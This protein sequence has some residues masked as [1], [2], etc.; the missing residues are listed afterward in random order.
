MPKS[1]SKRLLER[2][3]EELVKLIQQGDNEAF[4]ILFKRYEGLIYKLC[5]KFMTDYNIA[6]MYFDDL[7]DIAMFGLIKGTKD[8]VVDEE[9]SFLNY[10]WSI[11]DRHHMT[12]LS[13]L[14]DSKTTC[15]DPRIIEKTL[16]TMNSLQSSSANNLGLS[17]FDILNEYSKVFSTDE[18]NFLKHMYSGFEPLE[19]AEFFSWSKAKIYRLRRK[20]IRKLNK[21][22]KSN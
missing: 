5:Y 13:K 16:S 6:Q 11:V 21:I 22:N 9:K 1:E 14:I 17:I 12:F 10:W 2:Q 15:Y 18:L 3:D 4:E 19:I 20:A 8:Y 7:V